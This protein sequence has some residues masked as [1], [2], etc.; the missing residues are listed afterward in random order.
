[1][2]FEV[3]WQRILSLEGEEFCTVRNLE[4]TYK[5]VGTSLIPNR[6]QRKISQSDFYKAYKS[7]PLNGPGDINNLVQGPAY[8]YAILTDRRVLG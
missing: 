4:F 2:E 8:V 7:M 6:A 1:M 3:V 5:V